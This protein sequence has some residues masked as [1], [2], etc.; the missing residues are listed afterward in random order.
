MKTIYV[1]TGDIIALGS[2][3]AKSEKDTLV[4]IPNEA[5]QFTD[6]GVEITMY[7]KKS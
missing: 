7:I 6:T 4:D 1:K 3:S 2:K 5:Q